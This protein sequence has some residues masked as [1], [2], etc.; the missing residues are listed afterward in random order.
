KK[1]PTESKTLTFRG[2]SKHNIN[3]PYCAAASTLAAD[4][5]LPRAEE[6]VPPGSAASQGPAAPKTTM[7]VVHKAAQTAAAP[8]RQDASHRPLPPAS[9]HGCTV[10]PAH[11]GPFPEFRANSD[12]RFP[13]F[14]QESYFFVDLTQGLFRNVAG[15]LCAIAVDTF[16]I[17][18]IL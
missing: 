1:F 18:L 10:L 6:A 11:N 9:M 3:L 13:S 16:Q 17:C 15:F 2:K 5:L 4:V 14:S 7:P 12:S 8:L